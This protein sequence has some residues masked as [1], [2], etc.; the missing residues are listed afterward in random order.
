V[1]SSLMEE[2]LS[3][4]ARESGGRYVP[5]GTAST[6][7]TTL[8]SIFHQH[9]RQI[10]AREQQE[11]I[12]RRR[13][14]RY[15]WFLIPALALL[16]IAA[17]LS[18][19][20]LSTVRK[21]IAR[22]HPSF[23]GGSGA[24]SNSFSRCKPAH[25]FPQER[26]GAEDGSTPVNDRNTFFSLFSA[27][28]R[29]CGKTFFLVSFLTLLVTGFAQGATNTA[30]VETVSVA[31]TAAVPAGGRET[32]R[33]AQA[34]N[35]HGKY[36]EAAGTYLAA[37]RN[38]D[39]EEA[40]TYLFN[41]ALALHEAHAEA[42]AIDLLEPLVHS[43][44]VGDAA[45][46]LLGLA[47]F[48]M[49]AATNGPDAAEAKLAATET[50]AAAFQEALRMRPQES[51]RTRNLTRVAQ[52]LPALREEARIARILKQQGKT[53]PEQLITTLLQAQRALL[54]ET[55]AAFTNDAPE[56][57]RQLDAL[58]ERQERNS[59][60]WVPLKRAVLQ[61]PA[62]TNDQQRALFERIVENTRDAMN[63]TA[64]Q[65]RD[66]DS[67]A[68]LSLTR[69]EPPVYLFWRGMVT[70]PPLLDEAI[71]LQ[72]NVLVRAGQPIVPYRPDQ[73]EALELTC[74]FQQ[75]F[76]EWADQIV[77]T[78]QTDTNAPTLKPRDRAEIERLTQ[79]TIPLQQKPTAPN[80][81]QALKN[82]LRIRELLPKQK[83]QSQ[84]QPQP[85]A[86]PQDKPQD[87]PQPQPQDQPKDK[88]EQKQ[89]Q[90]KPEQQDQPP[91]NVQ[92]LLQRALQRE[93]EHETEKRQQMEHIPM[94]P[95]ER[96]W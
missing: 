43:R 37:S 55:P 47:A 41:A 15:P 1:H 59:D 2:A 31:T 28:L 88:P 68:C 52:Q 3:A 81:L 25:I 74:T 14:E 60:L 16:L 85:Q 46:E 8:G 73:P 44:R 76:P 62:L 53:P 32:A 66:L 20:R 13:I 18:R 94:L 9:L 30:P 19:G 72:S 80:Q 69:I 89:E 27:P 71:A 29:L 22:Q 83:Q 40:Q 86:K 51:R 21:S 36:R 45:A 77:K 92:D 38:A 12:A 17:G 75:R 34:L 93:K 24:Q 48:Q 50:A 26:R 56:Q 65:M 35:R 70:P 61:S 6:V 42:E 23:Q 10:S 4:I 33:E 91:K 87:K 39:T 96:D 84:Q 49:A 5:L 64:D 67:E 95:N 58:A 57:I 11:T 90:P 78:A 7:Q 54:K 79:E 82:L 63:G